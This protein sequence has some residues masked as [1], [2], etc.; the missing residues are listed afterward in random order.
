MA[1]LALGSCMAR[2]MCPN[3]AFKTT[4]DHGDGHGRKVKKKKLRELRHKGGCYCLGWAVDASWVCYMGIWTLYNPTP[5]TCALTCMWG[6]LAADPDPRNSQQLHPVKIQDTRARLLFSRHKHKHKH[7]HNQMAD[8]SYQKQI[9]SIKIQTPVC[10][11]F[12]AWVL[13]LLSDIRFVMLQLQC[14]VF[15]LQ[16]ARYLQLAACRACCSL[17]AMW[18]VLF[19]ARHLQLAAVVRVRVRVTVPALFS[20]RLVSILI[21]LGVHVDAW[22]CS[23]GRSLYE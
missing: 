5:P 12:G 11:E 22:A 10:S 13:M 1:T 16:S 19:A 15:Q 17:C 9:T 6:D 21:V 14:V 4:N 20:S 18:F 8:G 23:M 3:R 7:K 2:F